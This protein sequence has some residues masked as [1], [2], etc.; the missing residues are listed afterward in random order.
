MLENSL[1][2]L[3]IY[4]PHTKKYSPLI[5]AKSIS[6]SVTLTRINEQGTDIYINA[7]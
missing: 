4:V 7:E 3:E 6:R 1:K 5:D 2:I